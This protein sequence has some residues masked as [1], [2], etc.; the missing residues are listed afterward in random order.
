VAKKRRR[1]KKENKKRGKESVPL[2]E[3]RSHLSPHQLNGT[4]INHIV[5]HYR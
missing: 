3:G 4:A 2:K 5:S 1:K